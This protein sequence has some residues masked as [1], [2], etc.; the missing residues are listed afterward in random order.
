MYFKS[1]GPVSIKA[2]PAYQLDE[3]EEAIKDPEINIPS[4]LSANTRVCGPFSGFVSASLK[5]YLKPDVVGDVLIGE[6]F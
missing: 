2:N 4:Y 3:V 6:N 1:P 5:L